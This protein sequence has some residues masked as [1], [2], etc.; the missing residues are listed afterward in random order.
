[1][2]HLQWNNIGKCNANEKTKVTREEITEELYFAC[3][4]FVEWIKKYFRFFNWASGFH[5]TSLST[6]V[7]IWKYICL[8]IL[9]LFCSFIL[10]DPQ[11]INQKECVKFK[12][13]HTYW[14]FYLV[15]R[16]EIRV[17]EIQSYSIMKIGIVLFVVKKKKKK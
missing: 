2:F 16:I 1:M 12:L 11:Q 14:I 4:S 13:T 8:T 3:F 15:F 7:F 9:I 17:Y 6:W 5:T 10:Q